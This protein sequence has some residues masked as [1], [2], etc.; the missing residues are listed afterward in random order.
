VP[1]RKDHL[2]RLRCADLFLDTPNYNAHAT[3]ADSLWAGVPVLT[4]LGKTF[5]GR[6]A[7]SQLKALGMNELIVNSLDEYESLADRL[8]NFPNV[9]QEL[10]EKLMIAKDQAPLFNTSQYVKDLESLFKRMLERAGKDL[11][12][13]HLISN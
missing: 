4:V 1:E 11:P 12:A 5:A 13:D 8:T 10:R 7:A 6:V 9:L 3:S 2:S